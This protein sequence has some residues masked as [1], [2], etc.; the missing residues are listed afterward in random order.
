M[1]T[2]A[3]SSPAC[4][5]RSVAAN[6][7]AELKARRCP[8]AADSDAYA[9]FH[10]G[11]RAPRGEGTR[12][13]KTWIIKELGRRDSP[14]RVVLAESALAFGV[15]FVGFNVAL[16]LET[17]VRSTAPCVFCRAATYILFTRQ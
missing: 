1:S 17:P 3:K 9:V 4:S 8:L 10:S 6:V 5:L 2:T 11:T 7:E 13:S 15:N 14:V 16:C 12:Q